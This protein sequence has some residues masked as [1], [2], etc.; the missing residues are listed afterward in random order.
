MLKFLIILFVVS[1]VTF[2]LGGFLMKALYS[3]MGQDPSQRNFRDQ[4]KQSPS[5]GNVNVDYVPKNKQ[6]KS[7]FKGGEYVDY[8]EVE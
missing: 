6:S 1:Y 7:D 4:S 5:G 3:A 8:E 2:K